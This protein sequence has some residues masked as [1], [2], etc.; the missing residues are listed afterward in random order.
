VIVTK[1]GQKGLDIS[2]ENFKVLFQGKSIMPKTATLA[3]AVDSQWGEAGE[4]SP[5]GC[6]L[7]HVHFQPGMA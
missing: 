3:G 4:L 5:Q 7:L 6:N 2:G 1:F